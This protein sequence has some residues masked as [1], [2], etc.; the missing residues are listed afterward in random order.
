MSDFGKTDD[1]GPATSP[2]SIEWDY[3]IPLIN[4]RFM[5]WDWFKVSAIST[6]IMLVIVPIV[7]FV[8]EGELQLFPLVVAPVVFVVLWVLFVLACLLL[9]NHHNATFAVT[10]K[11]VGYQAGARERRL[12]RLAF[13]A[14]VLGGSASTAGAG[15]LAASRES[16]FTQW[17][18]V[19]A[20]KVYE[21][22]R[23]IALMDSWHVIQRLYVPEELFEH[24]AQ[25]VQRLHAEHP[26]TKEAGA[27]TRKAWW[28][29]AGWAALCAALAIGAQAWPWNDAEL[30]AR[31]ALFA[32]GAVLISGMTENIGRRLFGLLGLLGMV[33]HA[34]GLSTSAMEPLEGLFGTSRTFTLDTPLLA[35]AAGCTIVLFGLAAWRSFGPIRTK[36]GTQVPAATSKGGA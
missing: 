8:V 14:G 30:A 15:A 33:P 36:V 2:D 16:E 6:A 3:R 5:L 7:A 4:N 24:V 18:N 13:L 20:V 10:P 23:V 11:G 32:S 31:V 35:V 25:T 27:A 12:D 34:W 9:G 29:Y 28:W 22:V 17:R 21:D 1:A 26:P 19:Q